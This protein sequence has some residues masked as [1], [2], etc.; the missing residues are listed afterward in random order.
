MFLDIFNNDAFTLSSMSQAIDKATYTPDG[1]IGSG[2]F[3]PE[4]IRTESFGIETRKGTVSVVPFSERGEKRIVRD[5]TNLR[6]MI[7]ISTPRLALT[8]TIRAHELAFLREFNTE[9]QIAE[10]QKEIARR[11][12]GPTGLV[13]D[14]NLTLEKMAMGAIDGIILDH[15]GGELYNYFTILGETAAPAITLALSTL[16]GGA[17]R[18]EITQKVLRPMRA[19]AQGAQFQ[20]L[21][22]ICGATAFDNLN[23][24]PEYRE[25]YVAQQAGAELRESYFEKPVMFAG[26]EWVEYQGT[27]DDSFKVADDQVKFVPWGRNNIFSR[28]MSPGESFS[29]IGQLGQP[30]YSS[31]IVDDKRDEFV[32]LDVSTYSLMVNRRPDMTTKCTVS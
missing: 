18:V 2:I 13:T 30:L 19:K 6:S 4:P 14:V 32:D 29:Q 27:D 11:Q 1:I 21:R 12:F 26:V 10:V 16:S 24:N 15:L 22:A 7:N 23:K 8:S 25:S 9:D 3:T 28:V 17:A 20:Y 31:I 5:K